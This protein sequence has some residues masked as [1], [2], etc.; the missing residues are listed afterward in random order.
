MP[1]LVTGA[2]GLLGNNV[3]RQL[4]ERGDA[5][6]VLVR[7]ESD[8]RPLHGLDVE[9]QYGDIRD[10]G[11][12]CEAMRGASSVI[13]AAARVHLGWSGADET[14]AI[15]VDGANHVASAARDCGIRLV[16]VSTVDTL[17]PGVGSTVLDE[18]A[19]VVPS[20]R[21][22]YADSKCE[23]ERVVRRFVGDGLNAVVVNPSFIVGPWDWKPSSGRMMLTV[24]RIKPVF[25]PPGANDFCSA[26]AVAEATCNALTMG[27]TGARYI[28]SGERRTYLDAFRTFAK[29]ARVRRAAFAPPGHWGMF[30]AGRLGDVLTRLTGW[31][32]DINSAAVALAAR[33]R[34]YSHRRAVEELDYRPRP[35]E[36]AA[37]DAW[38]W[39][40]L[41]GYAKRRRKN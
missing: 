15:N 5:V 14:E 10:A 39:F 3:V 30:A 6:R 24:A 26:R 20:A 13:H 34:R 12:V 41:N 21:C 29:V 33:P 32:G 19:P 2:T 27:R 37:V 22:P 35:L 40:C 1:V 4:L 28:L 38:E 9:V 23:A 31:E 11:A 18:D 16:H 8:S 17:G 25:A 7:R 36:E